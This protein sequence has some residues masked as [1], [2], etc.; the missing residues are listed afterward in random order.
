M[1]RV[2]LVGNIASGKSAVESVLRE[3]DYCVLDTD[4][5]CHNLLESSE[6][7]RFAFKDYDILDEG[8]ISRDKLGKLV[9][10]NPELKSKLE[11]A[12]YP[13]L[14]VEI[15]KFFNSKTSE[16]LAFVAIPLLYEAGM[17]DLFDR[18]VF[19]YCDDEIRLKRLISRNAYSEDYA[20]LRMN[21]QMSQDEKVKK[22]DFVIYNNSTL[23]DLQKSI[24]H[25]VEQIR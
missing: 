23:E 15:E 9:F 25:L 10:S 21:A 19:I 5:V 6:S 4:V 17:E 18:V 13:D 3:L 14:K 22:A 11:N 2:A 1:L 20:K 8:N 12:L 24:K 16:Q 7:V